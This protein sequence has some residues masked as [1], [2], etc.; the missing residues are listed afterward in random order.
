MNKFLTTQSSINEL[1][2]RIKQH[3]IEIDMTQKELANKSGVSL[4]CI[5]MFE[6]GKDIQL[7]NF[8][9]I[10]SALELNEK[11]DLIVP[12]ISKRPSVIL[13]DVAERKRASKKNVVKESVDF[14]W[15]E[16]K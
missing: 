5:Q 8:I 15:G 16:D 14:V 2:K 6:S 9:K 10:L 7:S 3:R 13:S 4:R 11:L 1:S 12:D